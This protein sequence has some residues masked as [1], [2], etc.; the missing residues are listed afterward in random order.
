M[1]PTICEECRML[2]AGHPRSQGLNEME[3]TGLRGCE[4]DEPRNCG[5]DEHERKKFAYGTNEVAS[6]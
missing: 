3:N 2:I 4:S 5:Y 1:R 6:F